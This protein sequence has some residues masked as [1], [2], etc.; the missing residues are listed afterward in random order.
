MPLLKRYKDLDYA[1]L[2][3]HR[4]KRFPDDRAKHAA[5][6]GALHGVAR[7][8]R[9]H[10]KVARRDRAI[11]GGHLARNDSHNGQWNLAGRHWIAHAVLTGHEPGLVE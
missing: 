9:G 4:L 11:L 1:G 8:G 3:L 6:I 7:S 10:K 5:A 2:F